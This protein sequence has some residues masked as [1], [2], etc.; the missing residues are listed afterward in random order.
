MG[1]QLRI[2]SDPALKGSGKTST[3]LPIQFTPEKL[4]ALNRGDARLFFF[5]RA[6]YQDS[7][8]VYTLPFEEMYDGAFPGNLL[9]PPSD[10]AFK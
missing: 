1:Q 9:A 6:E 8:G 5:A 4:E 7:T 2:I 10:V 3:P